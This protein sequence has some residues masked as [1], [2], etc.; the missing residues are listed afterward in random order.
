MRKN[1]ALRAKVLKLLEENPDGLTIPQMSEI[2]TLPGHTMNH[3]L[4]N[5]IKHTANIYI[6][7]WIPHRGR[8]GYSP[9]YVAVEIPEDAP[10]PDPINQKTPPVTLGE[11][12]W[13]Q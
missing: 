8:G 6:D 9:V 5:V 4:R 10:K 2:L 1:Y 3:V 13:I 12:K 11:T 7:R